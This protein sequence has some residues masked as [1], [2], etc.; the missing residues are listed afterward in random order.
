MRRDVVAITPRRCRGP[1]RRSATVTRNLIGSQ[2]GESS[3]R[4]QI[5][6][7]PSQQEPVVWELPRERCLVTEAC[8]FS[9]I[10]PSAAGLGFRRTTADDLEEAVE[11]K[12]STGARPSSASTTRSMP[13]AVYSSTRTLRNP[14]SRS[15]ARTTS[16]AKRGSL[17]RGGGKHG[18][19]LSKSPGRRCWRMLP[20]AAGPLGLTVPATRALSV[21]PSRGRG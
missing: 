8:R 14:G 20:L 13:M 11:R 4:A 16:S 12:R 18:D 17:Y 5:L 21:G 2:R 7:S 6:F 9:A 15:S 19:G 3:A 10:R 1:T